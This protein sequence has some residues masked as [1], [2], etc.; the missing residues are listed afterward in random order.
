M[1]VFLSKLFSLN[2]YYH[3]TWLIVD[4]FCDENASVNRVL[5]FMNGHYALVN[6]ENVDVS[7]ILNHVESK[8]EYF[9][10]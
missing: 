7:V 10:F 2:K 1:K 6:S 9:P 5:Y 8:E 4:V 3:L